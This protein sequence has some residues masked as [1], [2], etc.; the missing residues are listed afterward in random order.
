MLIAQLGADG[1]DTA[2]LVGW[3]HTH[4]PVIHVAC[5]SQFLLTLDLRE[6]ATLFEDE[7]LTMDDLRECSAKELKVR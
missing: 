6:F 4:V 1:D 3:I 2:T 7:G 5:Q